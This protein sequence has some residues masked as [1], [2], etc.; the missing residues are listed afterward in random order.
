MQWTKTAGGVYIAGPTPGSAQAVFLSSYSSVA[1]GFV[2]QICGVPQLAL[3]PPN[4]WI[5]VNLAPL[6]TTIVPTL[7]VDVGGFLIIT[8]GQNTGLADLAIALQTPGAGTNPLNYNVQGIG[9]G[10]GGG[11]RQTYG[12]RPVVLKNNCLEFAWLRGNAYAGEFPD[13]PIQNYPVGAA[14]EITIV[15][16]RAYT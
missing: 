7:A 5:P 12:G 15:I 4:Q 3:P 2:Y 14:Y 9:I 16:E 10:P 8:D 6:L 1:A 11:I 13:G